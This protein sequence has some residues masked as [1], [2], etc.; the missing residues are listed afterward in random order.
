MCQVIELAS[1]HNLYKRVWLRINIKRKLKFNLDR[2]SLETIYITII[3]PL[4]E[5]GDNIWNNCTQADKNDLDKIQNEA[6]TGATQLVSINKLYKE[7][8]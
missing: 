6:A 3:R 8:C 4:L 1:T 2:K 5:Y 7:M